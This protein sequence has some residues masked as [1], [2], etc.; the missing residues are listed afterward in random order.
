MVEKDGVSEHEI[1]RHLKRHPWL[2]GSEYSELLDR[3]NWTRDD[4]LDFMLRRSADGYLEIIEIKTP[5]KEPLMRHDS[6][7]DSYFASSKL[8]HVIGQVL[9][10]IDE[11]ERNR[12]SIIASD[13][14]DPF[15][16]RAKIII[17]RDQDESGQAAL[18]SYNA[19]LNR[20]EVLTFDQLLRIGKRTIEIFESV[21]ED[22]IETTGS[23]WDDDIPF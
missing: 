17:G 15:K 6:G 7:H 18:R 11:V 19:H 10:Y 8:S 9:R 5:F 1:Q 16:I 23:E 3:R 20:I 14:L 13:K 22:E 2:F 4:S 12:N 21:V